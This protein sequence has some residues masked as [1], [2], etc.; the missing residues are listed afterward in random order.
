MKITRLVHKREP[1]DIYIG[2]PTKWGNPWSHK[3]GANANQVATRKE[4]VET[5]EK[6][7]RGDL[8]Q[9]G[10]LVNLRKWILDNLHTLEGQTLGCW[11]SPAL[12]HGDILI[13]LLRE[14]SD[15]IV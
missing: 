2:R 13:K 7:L 9:Y 8:E 3:K 4:A 12:C 10:V 15:L 1:H 6:W 5:Y 14:Q 11:C